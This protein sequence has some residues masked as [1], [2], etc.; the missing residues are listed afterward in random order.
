MAL[1]NTMVV[2]QNRR[3]RTMLRKPIEI[4]ECID[5]KFVKKEIER[6]FGKDK[7]KTVH[8]DTD[9]IFKDELNVGKYYLNIFGIFRN[10]VK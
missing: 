4:S 10:K 3:Q 8:E 6:I 5:D 2:K 9:P 7:D 1:E